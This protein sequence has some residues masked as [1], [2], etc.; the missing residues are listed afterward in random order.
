MLRHCRS[1]CRG[2][3]TRKL[4]STFK[5]LAEAGVSH[6]A[7]CRGRTEGGSEMLASDY[8][9]VAAPKAALRHCCNLCRGRKDLH[10][11]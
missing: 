5:L 9:L 10:R 1:S 7:P 6:A 8:T 4:A 11:S 3:G 2:G